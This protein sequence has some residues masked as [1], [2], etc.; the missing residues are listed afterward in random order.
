M[1]QTVSPFESKARSAQKALFVLK[2]KLSGEAISADIKITENGFQITQTLKV[3]DHLVVSKVIGSAKGFSV[4]IEEMTV[5][6]SD[7]DPVTIASASLRTDVRGNEIISGRSN[8]SLGAYFGLQG[9]TII[10]S[11]CTN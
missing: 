5:P 3:K 7:H 8:G 11:I 4:A 9:A 6:K 2:D 10:S 1:T